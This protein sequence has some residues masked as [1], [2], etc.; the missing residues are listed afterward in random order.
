MNAKAEAFR[1]SL[2]GMT[3]EEIIQT[4]VEVFC[5]KEDFKI[6]FTEY[7]NSGT[8][9]AIQ[10]Q[11]M[12]QELD[13][14]R[15]ELK[16][17]REQN[18]H[19]TE[20]RYMR[21]KDLFGRSTEKTEDILNQAANGNPEN[22]DPLEE[23]PAGN[24]GQ[25]EPAGSGRK[26]PF[27]KGGRTGKKKKTAGKRKIDLSKLPLCTKYDYD[28]EEYDRIYGAGN[29]RIAFWEGHS[30]VGLIK[31][32]TYHELTYTPILSIGLEHTMERPVQKE[33][34]LPKSLVSPSLLAQIIIDKYK[35][36]IPLYRQEHDPGRFGIPLSRQTMSGW[37]VYACL[38]LFLPVYDYMTAELRVC[39]Y[40]QCDETT[41]LV[42]HD[43]RDAGAKSYIWAHRTSELLDGPVIIIYCYEKTRS[44]DHLRN[45]YAGQTEPFYLTSDAYIGYPSFAEEMDGIVILCG[46]LMHC[47]RKFVEALAVLN[48]KGLTDEQ[49]LSLPETQ[50]ILLAGE[51]YDADEPLKALNAQERHE[52]RQNDVKGKVDNFFD[53]VHSFD[54]D[55]PSLSEKM[56]TALQYSINQESRLRMFLEDGNIPIDD[57]ATERSIRPIAQGRRS[58]LFSNTISGARST[59]IAS[60][61]IETAKAN[62]ADPYYYLKYLL[63]KLPAL[64]INKDRSFLPDMMPWSDKYRKYE[65]DEKKKLVGSHM[66]P[67]GNEKP[68]A[69]GKQNR[70]EEI[71]KAG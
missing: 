60:S 8:E 67:P 5:E 71:S 36:F 4:A 32:T 34:L 20:V 33:I 18:Q 19:L 53:F 31:Q 63:E 66:A 21:E 24:P 52:K 27:P 7:Q 68:H 16:V 58:Y 2:S 37:I 3:R 28:F 45:F 55:D 13:A 25:E 15:K 43:G 69:R 1:N 35:L 23:D 54:P 70:S 6:R 64:L 46:C 30:K 38:E 47:R 9:M 11:Q 10:F 51:I 57:G 12:K 17:L 49:I 62:G 22:P 50:G 42:I 56:K 29:W 14:A 48:T 41:Y 65:A 40:Q 44:A 61:L 59:A 39:K 26:I